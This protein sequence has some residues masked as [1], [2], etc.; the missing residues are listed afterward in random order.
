MEGAGLLAGGGRAGTYDAKKVLGVTKL[1]VVRAKAFIGQLIGTDP[2][3]VDI[4]VVGGHAGVTILPLLS[5]VL[6]P[7][8]CYIYMAPSTFPLPPPPPLQ[9]SHTE[10]QRCAPAAAMKLQSVGCRR[11]RRAW[12]WPV[13]Q[14]P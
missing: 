4:P 3:R 13:P 10:S 6:S 8:W 2:R 12:C 5:Q 1:D 14:E 7:H 11:G 9:H